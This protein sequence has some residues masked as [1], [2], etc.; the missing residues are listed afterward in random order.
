MFA[1]KK[2]Q[3][4]DGGL[5]D[6]SGKISGECLLRLVTRRTV[7]PV[8]EVIRLLNSG[9]SRDDYFATRSSHL[10]IDSMT[11]IE[12]AVAPTNTSQHTQIGTE[13]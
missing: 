3:A 8:P 9:I 13:V 12:Q 5:Q 11:I 7:N 2:L 10:T 4:E 6:S 1:R